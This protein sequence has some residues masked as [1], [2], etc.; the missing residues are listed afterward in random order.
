MDLN[1]GHKLSS[2]EKKITTVPG[3]EPG[4]A[5]WEARMLPLCYAASRMLSDFVDT[6]PGTFQPKSGPSPAPT[7]LVAVSESVTGNV[8]IN[9]LSLHDNLT[10]QKSGVLL[11]TFQGERGRESA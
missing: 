1:T 7:L 2:K 4:V 10:K 11:K 3:F 6:D 8:V 5:G 9:I